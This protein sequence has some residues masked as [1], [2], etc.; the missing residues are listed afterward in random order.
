MIIIILIIIPFD[1]F[2]YLVELSH[3]KSKLIIEVLTSERLL[4]CTMYDSFL[5]ISKCQIL[6]VNLASI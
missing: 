1:V 5:N 3:K 6:L 2:F 4:T